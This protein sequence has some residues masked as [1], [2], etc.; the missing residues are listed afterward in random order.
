MT[1]RRVF[2]PYPPATGC[3]PGRVWHASQCPAA[4]RISPFAIESAEKLAGVGGSIGAFCGRH[5]RTKNPSS[6]MT[7]AASIA[8]K[9]RR[10]KN[11]DF[12][13]ARWTPI[14]R[15]KSENQASAAKVPQR[16]QLGGGLGSAYFIS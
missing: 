6:P 16:Q 14:G 12:I 7:A 13:T 15:V 3:P 8:I 1:P 4:E 9:T 2:T 11:S 5:A 10:V